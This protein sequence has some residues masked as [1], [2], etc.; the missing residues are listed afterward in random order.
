MAEALSKI[1]E[2]T[3]YIGI[4]IL[5]ALATIYAI[6]VS[7]MGEMLRWFDDQIREFEAKKKEAYKGFSD[8]MEARRRE[9]GDPETTIKKLKKEWKSR[10]EELRKEERPFRKRVNRLS[11]EWILLSGSLILASLGSN[12]LAISISHSA[13][14]W[15]WS[16]IPYS[17]G[18]II[19]LWG[20]INVALTLKEANQLVRAFSPKGKEAFDE[21]LERLIE[22]IG[23][24]SPEFE[25]HFWVNKKRVDT[26]TIEKRQE[27]LATLCINNDSR[28]SAKETSISLALP[29]GFTLR[30]TVDDKSKFRPLHVETYPEGAEYRYELGTF[31]AYNTYTL[32][33][34]IKSEIQKKGGFDMYLWISSTTHERFEH[35]LKV[36]IVNPK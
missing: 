10:E 8:A 27:Q 21:L 12:F 26:L 11:L 28:F 30:K 2:I 15:K 23:L 1:Y 6:I 33:F 14:L 5:P 34:L 18:T 20:L 4:A 29:K 13:T 32:T 22:E 35:K 3:A 19:L 17:I 16:V 7:L 24:K 9:G 31:P 25:A 36:R